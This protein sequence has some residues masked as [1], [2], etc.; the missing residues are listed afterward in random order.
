[1]RDK[2]RDST[3]AIRPTERHT[4]N[5]SILEE[6]H[7]LYHGFGK[8]GYYG[9]NLGSSQTSSSFRGVNSASTTE[10]SRRKLLENTDK[11]EDTEFLKE[12]V[13]KRKNSNRHKEEEYELEDIN[14]RKDGFEGIF[15]SSD[16][17]DYCGFEC[18]ED[19]GY[20]NN[21]YDVRT[22]IDND[23]AMISEREETDGEISCNSKRKR[24]EE[25]KTPEHGCE[26]IIGLCGIGKALN[27]RVC[28]VGR[29]TTVMLIGNI[30]AGKSTLINWILQENVQ[31]TGMAI[32]T[33]GITYVVQGKQINDIGGETALLLLPELRDVVRRNP[34][35]LMSLSVKTCPL[36]SIK[37]K[38]INFIDTP[39]LSDGDSLYS[40][41]IDGV[42]RDIA[43][44]V[45][46]LIL[47]CIDS[48][49][50]SLSKRLI[51]LSKYLAENLSSKT[52]FI[53]TKID[54]V[55]TEEDR[56]KVMCQITQNL[57]SKI[58]IKHGFDLIPVFVPGA[59]DGSYLT[60]YKSFFESRNNE[61]VSSENLNT[62]NIR[63][64]SNKSSSNYMDRSSAS[65]IQ[66]L[67][68]L[69]RIKDVLTQIEKV[70]D[71]K[72]QDDIISLLSDS[73]MLLKINKKLIK[74][75]TDFEK[76][77]TKISRQKVIYWSSACTVFFTCIALGVYQLSQ[78]FGSKSSLFAA[79]LGNVKNNNLISDNA[80]HGEEFS[81]PGESQKQISYEIYNVF[82][83]ILP[84]S[85][86]ILTL[87]YR[88][89]QKEQTKMSPENLHTLRKYYKMLKFIQLRAAEIH[90]LYVNN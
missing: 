64:K 77:K 30:S 80:N 57:A 58:Q 21:F 50:N 14:E 15:N 11:R 69:N 55:P 48:A 51:G 59:K 68:T 16:Y 90:E 6:I 19:E 34:S 9:I 10:R 74:E 23:G 56:V 62:S 17:S 29:K 27:A 42:L 63:S 87:L 52:R 76:N 86:T 45:C 81:F 38:N 31:K 78:S 89:I 43:E 75:K 82:W 39:G 26:D 53:L 88:N 36:N 60:N 5:A 84:L 47:V 20:S 85:L 28:S 70:V 7:G 66:N 73:S 54:E 37:F 72:V 83:L 35:L 32:E 18:V 24:V 22:S 79:L 61:Q 25:Q 2:A 4:L 41:D 71:R 65:N 44:N 12:I 67:P 3:L 49:G 40:F 1:M 33:C 8:K 13:D 46:D